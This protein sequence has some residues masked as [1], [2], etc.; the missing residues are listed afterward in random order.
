VHQLLWEAIWINQRR[1]LYDM[2]FGRFRNR[3]AS[4]TNVPDFSTTR[5]IDCLNFI[6]RLL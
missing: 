6:L 1:I 4:H 2:L 3:T 5:N